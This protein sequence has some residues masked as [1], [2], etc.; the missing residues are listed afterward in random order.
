MDNYSIE[1]NLNPEI[2]NNKEHYFW[3]IIKTDVH[4]IASN[5]GHGWAETVIIAFEIAL[6]YYI[7][8][9]QV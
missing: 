1:I 7:T 9:I 5:C 6:N 3:C 8:N 4:N 2:F